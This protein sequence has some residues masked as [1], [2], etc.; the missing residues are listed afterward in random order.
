VEKAADRLLAAVSESPELEELKDT[1]SRRQKLYQLVAEHPDPLWREIGQQLRDGHISPSEL[2]STPQY[3]EH[4]RAGM[5]DGLERLNHMV[6]ALEDHLR[7]DPPPVEEA[8]RRAEPDP[9][10]DLSETMGPI[11]RRR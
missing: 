5:A 7:A 3:R 2:L 11:L 4:L 1:S 6:G 10:E 8:P 9:D